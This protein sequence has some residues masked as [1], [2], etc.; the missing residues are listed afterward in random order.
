MLITSEEL[1]INMTTKTFDI[2]YS[3]HFQVEE[4]WEAKAVQGN[5]EKIKL[6]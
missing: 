4:I 3:G 1:V 6:T 5:N 2:P